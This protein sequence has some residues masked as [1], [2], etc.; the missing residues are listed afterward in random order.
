MK[1]YTCWD[2]SFGNKQFFAYKLTIWLPKQYKNKKFPC[3]LVAVVYK[4][5]ALCLKKY[6]VCLLSALC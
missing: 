6:I 2:T 3:P 5:Y 1:L 4:M